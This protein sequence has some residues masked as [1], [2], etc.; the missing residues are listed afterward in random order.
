MSP[1]RPP[2]L[3]EMLDTQDGVVGEH[4]G[5]GGQ[6]VLMPTLV[7][8]KSSNL[9]CRKCDGRTGDQGFEVELQD[10]LKERIQEPK[11]EES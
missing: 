10:W 1:K 11:G 6:V 2:T 9:G 7:G 4:K 3:D 5:C 8:S